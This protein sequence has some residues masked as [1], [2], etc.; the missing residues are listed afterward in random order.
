ML[1]QAVLFF[2]LYFFV[3]AQPFAFGLVWFA[4]I[5]AMGW[6]MLVGNLM[7][8]GIGIEVGLKYIIIT[9]DSWSPCECERA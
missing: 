1:E 9:I 7:G 6:C 4:C 5:I 8:F 2:W 3:C